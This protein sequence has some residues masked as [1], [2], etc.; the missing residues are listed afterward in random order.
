M[1]KDQEEKSKRRN[2]SQNIGH[3][4]TIVRM[5]ISEFDDE[6]IF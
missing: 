6:N 2:V 5:L 1:E 4:T 3:I